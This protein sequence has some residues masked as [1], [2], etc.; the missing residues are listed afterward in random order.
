MRGVRMIAFTGMLVAVG[1]AIGR[2]HGIRVVGLDR[3]MW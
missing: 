1:K 3:G 2:W